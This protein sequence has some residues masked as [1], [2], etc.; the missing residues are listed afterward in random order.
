VKVKGKMMNCL[1]PDLAGIEP[2]RG[3]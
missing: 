2:Y 3:R 1:R